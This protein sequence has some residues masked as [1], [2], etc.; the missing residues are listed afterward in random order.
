MI[1]NFLLVPLIFAIQ[2]AAVAQRSVTEYTPAQRAALE[3]FLSRN[4][5]YQ[6]IPETW[7][8]EAVLKSAKNDWGIGKNFKPYFQE[9]D[10]NRDGLRDFA[11]ILLTGK[12]AKDPKSG[13]H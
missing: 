6:F 5:G 10:F 13:L 9:G 1:R 11:V 7:F 8:D 2:I 4:P 3:R 12:N